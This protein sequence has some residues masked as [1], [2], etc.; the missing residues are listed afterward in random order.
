M[1]RY[2]LK[3]KC[4]FVDAKVYDDNSGLPTKNAKIDDVI[5][6]NPHVMDTST[7]PATY[8]PLNDAAA[9]IARFIV[10]GVDTDLIPQ[11]LTSE[12]GSAVKNPGK[13]VA[14]VLAMLF[15]KYMVNRTYARAYDAPK[16]GNEGT[17]PGKYLLDFKVNFFGVGAVKGPL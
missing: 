2:Q 1:A 12:Y 4:L 17:H 15:P 6:A 9:F 10:L 11:I 7:S 13:E 3:N 16:K 5:L 8:L 14:D